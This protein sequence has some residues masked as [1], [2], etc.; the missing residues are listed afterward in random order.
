M[1]S[2]AELA[3]DILFD[4]IG[5][6]RS[7]FELM[8]ELAAVGLC[9]LESS[10]KEGGKP[11]FT[12]RQT[13]A[14]LDLGFAKVSLSALLSISNRAQRVREELDS[15]NA[16]LGESEQGNSAMAIDRTASEKEQTNTWQS[17]KDRMI[18]ILQN[19][20]DDSSFDE[21]LRE[22]AMERMIE[23][24]RADYEAGR[25]M[26]HEEVGEWIKEKWRS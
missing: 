1:K 9:R 10:E 8:I 6:G 23:R 5:G 2:D 21:L 22:L 13:R 18:A 14:H 25:T 3:V 11:Y 20:P 19:Q 16:E 12:L 17:A 24:G 7:F 26:T 4:H 15:D